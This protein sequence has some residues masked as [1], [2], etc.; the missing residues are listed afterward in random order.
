MILGFLLVLLT[1]RSDI[2]VLGSKEGT[3]TDKHGR[4]S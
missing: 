2:I 3:H 4:V 1:E